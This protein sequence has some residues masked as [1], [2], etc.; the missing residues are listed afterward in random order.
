MYVIVLV[1]ALDL[2]KME[3]KLNQVLRDETSYSL[4][5]WLIRNES[6]YRNSDLNIDL[7]WLYSTLFDQ[8][9]QSDV[10]A[11]GSMDSLLKECRFESQGGVPINL[12]KSSRFVLLEIAGR[13]FTLHRTIDR[14]IMGVFKKYNLSSLGEP[15]LLYRRA[16]WTTPVEVKR[17]LNRGVVILNGERLGSKFD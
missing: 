9:G 5:E 2:K 8:V 11:N 7:E 13:D 1:M 17:W 3:K 16:E 6:S 10:I 4:N 15:L 12:I 14:V